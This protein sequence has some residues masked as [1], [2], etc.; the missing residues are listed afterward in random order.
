MWREVGYLLLALPAGAVA[1]SV[2]VT[3]WAVALSGTTAPL[4]YWAV[5]GRGDFLYPGNRLLPA[6]VPARLLG[7]GLLPGDRRR[8]RVPESPPK[9]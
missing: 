5:P 3:A 2:V 8:N 1:F 4:W 9:L 6:P 7:H